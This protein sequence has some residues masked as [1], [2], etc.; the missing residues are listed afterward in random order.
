[1]ECRR[2]LNRRGASRHLA[3]AAASGGWQQGSST[4]AGLFLRRATRLGATANGGSAARRSG[5]QSAQFGFQRRAA[6]G[7]LGDGPAG[8]TMD[9]ATG[10]ASRADTPRRW[11][12]CR[13]TSA[14][15]WK[16]GRYVRPVLQRVIVGRAGLAPQRSGR[17]AL[18]GAAFAR[19]ARA[20][21]EHGYEGMERG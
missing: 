21:A 10:R 18:G 16:L 20:V 17:G 19:G 6:S 12:A 9:P 7:G 13:L 14:V 1:M 8:D 15:S 4:A 2:D 11:R 3:H 5:F